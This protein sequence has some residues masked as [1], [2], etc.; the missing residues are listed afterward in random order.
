MSDRVH[1]AQHVLG[2]MIDFAHEEVLLLLALLAFGNVLG[3]AAEAH[4]PALRPGALKIGKSVSLHPA[5]LAITPP[6]PEF[7]RGA[8]RIGGVERRLAVRPKPLPVVPMHPP[9]EV[10]HPYLLS[11]HLQ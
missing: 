1:D 6:D 5:D 8:L 2:A 7:A 3:G 4:G 10:L 9:H 11:R